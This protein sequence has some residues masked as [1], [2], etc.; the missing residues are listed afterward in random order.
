MY[1]AHGG[2]IEV[3]RTSHSKACNVDQSKVFAH[4]KLQTLYATLPYHNVCS[5]LTGC[6][7]GLVFELNSSACPMM[8]MSSCV[9]VFNPRL[10]DTACHALQL[11][12]C[13]RRAVVELNTCNFTTLDLAKSEMYDALRRL[14]THWQHVLS[15]CNRSLHKQARKQESKPVAPEWA[16]SDVTTNIIAPS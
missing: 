15:N 9:R 12:C 11:R 13:G 6:M 5:K 8:P 4:L 10:Q 2:H 14:P 3:L 7:C 16:C 1:A